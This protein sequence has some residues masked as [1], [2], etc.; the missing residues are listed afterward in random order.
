MEVRL[1]YINGGY[2]HSLKASQLI[3][4]GLAYGF[5]LMKKLST[6]QNQGIEKIKRKIRRQNISERLKSI[7]NWKRG[8]YLVTSSWYWSTLGETIE[9][10][11]CPS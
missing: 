4:G 1:D 7:M 8:L 5:N 2:D 6:L 3:V 9:I 11:G 10:S